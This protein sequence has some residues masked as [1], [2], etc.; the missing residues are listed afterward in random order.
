LDDLGLHLRRK[1]FRN[2]SA[3]VWKTFCP[4]ESQPPS[5]ELSAFIT[6]RITSLRDN[7]NSDPANNKWA[8][9]LDLIELLKNPKKAQT[10]FEKQNA[11][12]LATASCSTSEAEEKKKKKLA[13]LE[14]K[15]GVGVRSMNRYPYGIQFRFTISIRS[16]MNPISKSS[17]SLCY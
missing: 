5:S 12:A 14:K 9:T 3:T 7:M 6:Q 8:S 10:K 2:T 17:N 4:L 13:K 11:R 1:E 15:L 16:P